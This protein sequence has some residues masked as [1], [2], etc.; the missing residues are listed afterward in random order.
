MREPRL[1]SEMFELRTVGVSSQLGAT[2]PRSC[3]RRRRPVRHRSPLHLRAAP[4]PILQTLIPFSRKLPSRIELA[5]IK[6]W[7]NALTSDRFKLELSMKLDRLVVDRLFG[8]GP[9]MPDSETAVAFSRMLDELG[10]QEQ[11]G[12]SVNTW[13]YTSLGTELK[14]GLLVVFMGP[15]LGMGSPICARAKSPSGQRRG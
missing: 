9:W 11:V 13:R 10:L 6:T 3:R 12:S 1:L 4:C 2:R 14:I 7:R 5:C 8:D 15:A